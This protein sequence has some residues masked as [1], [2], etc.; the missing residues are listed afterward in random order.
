[1]QAAIL[2]AGEGTRMRPLTLTRPKTMLPV[3]GKPI[4][5]HNIEALRDAGVEEILLIT[6]YCEEIIKDYF[7]DGED[8]GVKIK[9]VTQEERLGTAHAIGH[10]R[11]ILNEEFI[12]LNGDI[13]LDSDIISEMIDNYE[14]SS[15]DSMMI[16]T[17]VEDPSPF[18]VVELEANCIKNI[19]EKPSIEEAPSNFIN[20]GIYVFN[21]DILNKIEDTELSL[22]GEYEITDSL[23]LQINDGKQVM[24]FITDKKW[25]DVG[26][27]WELLEINEDFLSDIPNEIY[28]EI[29]EG[30]TIHGNIYLGSNSIIRSGTYIQGPVIIGDNC[31][32]GPNT[33][34]RG[35]SYIG[36]N[37]NLG[38]AVEIKN[39]IIM[40]DT[41][42]NHLTYVGDSI[43]GANC[44]LAAGTNLANLRF[45]DG[46]VKL[47]IKGERVDSGRRKLGAIFGDGVQTGINT[48]FNPGVII[49]QNTAISS[50]A[51]VYKDIGSNKL[52]ISKQKLEVF[53]K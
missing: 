13:I 12:V 2:T 30:V 48:S 39:S 46:N 40:H 14:S 50:G 18:G 21:Q 38:N 15:A 42:I 6:G 33:Y 9:Y 11:N 1:M 44:N 23:Q 34:I 17:E 49:G 24:G 19:V 7:G 25:I 26:R 16:L 36:N 43:I 35:N 45:D 22:R 53:E 4:I 37:V 41:N 20:T 51:I 52:V 3:G 27:P 8:F 29:E 5:Q 32:I 31:D 10:A 28:G 47:T